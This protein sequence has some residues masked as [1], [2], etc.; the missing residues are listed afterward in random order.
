MLA[1]LAAGV[2]SIPLKP[3]GFM[4]HL[5]VLAKA[6][7]LDLGLTVHPNLKHLDWRLGAAALL[8][9]ALQ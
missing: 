4:A 1:S 3:S 7:E 6:E 9:A 5:R 2:P 8:L